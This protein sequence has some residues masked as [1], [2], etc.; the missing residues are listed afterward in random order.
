V[1][2]APIEP[3]TIPIASAISICRFIA[4]LPAHRAD[5]DHQKISAVKAACG[6]DACA[7]HLGR[8][9][10]PGSLTDSFHGAAALLYRFG[11]P[12]FFGCRAPF[13]ECSLRG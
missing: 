3:I 9:H 5:P 2:P 1:R 13:F 4:F 11:R 6:G 10:A 12:G 7:D 8:G